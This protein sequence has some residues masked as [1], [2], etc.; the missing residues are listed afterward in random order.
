[1]EAMV[2]ME[3]SMEEEWVMA[4]WV[5]ADMVEDTAGMVVMAMEWVQ[6]E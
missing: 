4:G 5:M 1:M 2:P 6:W 3:V